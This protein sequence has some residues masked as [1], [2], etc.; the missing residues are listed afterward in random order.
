MYKLLY[1]IK[2]NTKTVALQVLRDRRGLHV[3]LVKK[4]LKAENRYKK[5]QLLYCEL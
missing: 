2:E 3:Y 4:A 5:W 1:R